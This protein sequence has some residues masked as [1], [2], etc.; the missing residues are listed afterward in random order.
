MLSV[1]LKI[2]LIALYTSLAGMLWGLDTGSI[3]PLTQMAQF[4]NS[5]GYISS[6]QLGIYVACILL[7]ASI[8]SLCSGHV[9]DVISRKYGILTGGL[10]VAVGT[11]LS[12]S[13]N[14][15]PALICA[16]LITGI[17]QG[18]S[19][20]VVTIYLCEIAPQNIR[21]TVATMLQ[22][23]ITVGIAAGYFIA[24]GSSRLDGSLAW[25]TP[26][27][28][29]ACVAA[30]LS[31]G[32]AFMPFSPRWLVQH[33]RFKQARDVLS[34]LRLTTKE[35]DEELNSIKA[36]LE[37][38]GALHA[39]FSEVFSKRY[40]KRSLLGIF[41]MGFQMLCGIDAVLYYA[42]ILFTQAGFSSQRASFLASGISGIVNLVFTIPAQLLVDKWGRRF[43]YIA[44]GI[45][46]ASCFLAIGSIY[47]AHGGKANG[48]VY[49]NGK[50]AQ[51]AVIILI[52]I[53]IANF[54]WSWAVV[55][56]IYTCEIM[57]TRLRA[58]ACAFQQ[59]A[60]W[61]V[62]FAVALAAPVFLRSSPSGPYFLFGTATCFV[63]LVCYFFMHET[64][65]KSLEEI[66]GLFEK[67]DAVESTST[68]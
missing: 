13:A 57:P 17:G 50:P 65:G 55:T 29:E 16:R 47:A 26:F 1:T 21:G 42:P 19:I 41:M 7:S 43:P 35:V 52:Y 2:Y 40:I 9:A 56:K 30:M 68:A 63:T 62:N 58:K 51:W 14:N 45:A 38:E 54:A 12:A 53:F 37:E 27:I 4:S 66:K 64:K 22:L 32:M 34:K 10:I 44:G 8:S 25:R 20:S 6:S 5:I 24:Y 46:I 67:N 23:L 59:L 33:G 39:T 28:I 61:V 60:N 36:S 3:G 31:M 15:F 48:E 49:L 11:V 18:Q